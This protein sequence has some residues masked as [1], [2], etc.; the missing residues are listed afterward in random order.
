ME[1]KRIF[2]VTSGR[3]DSYVINGAFSSRKNAE[4]YIK[5]TTYK[6]DDSKGNGMRIEPFYAI[7]Y[8]VKLYAK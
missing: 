6:N 4:T 3:N 5:D 7:D 2:I 8:E 1:N